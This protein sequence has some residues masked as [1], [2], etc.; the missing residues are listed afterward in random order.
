MNYP[1]EYEAYCCEIGLVAQSIKERAF[2]YW[3]AGF[4]TGQRQ[5]PV[6]DEL[7]ARI[8]SEQMAA[9]VNVL[10]RD[11]IEYDPAKVAFRAVAA[12]DALLR[13]LATI[14]RVADRS[15]QGGD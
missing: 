1:A 7:R 8:A 2:P 15:A 9:M 5:D 12:A 4:R 3:S 13:E 11:Y 10:Q 6:S 14:R